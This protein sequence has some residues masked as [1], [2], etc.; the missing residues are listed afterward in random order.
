MAERRDN[1]FTLVELLVGLVIMALLMQLAFGALRFGGAAWERVVDSG[2]TI[3]ARTSVARFLS[4]RLGAMSQPNPP[5][6]AAS[7]VQWWFAGQ[8]AEMT[9]VAPWARGAAP[10]GMYRFRLWRERDG[11]SGAL[12]L[13]WQP[14]MRGASEEL[15][16]QW[17]GERLILPEVDDLVLRYYGAAK[18]GEAPGWHSLWTRNAVM[19][20]LVEISIAGPDAEIILPRL[21]I[22]TGF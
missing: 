8:S 7:S 12:H 1:G 11:R 14:E 13:S 6:N 4:A 9:F 16:S 17:S 22:A 19:P 15:R 21:V 2:E 3:D 5:N 18:A 20:A 10:D